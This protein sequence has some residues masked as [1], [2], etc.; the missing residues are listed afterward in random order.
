VNSLGHTRSVFALDHLL[1]TPDTFIRTVLPGMSRATAIVHASPALGAGFTA[2]TAEF[3][4]D[5]GLGPAQGQR[6]IYVLDGKLA[7]KR[8]EQQTELGSGGYAFVAQESDHFISSIEPSRLFVIEKPYT[9]CPGTGTPSTFTGNEAS[10]ENQALG[11]DPDLQVRPLLP[12]RPEFDF[13]VNT[14][15][16]APGASLS[17]VEI[18]VMEHA[19]L[20]LEGGGIYRLGDR[21]YPV[22]AGDFIWMRAY[23][24]QWFGAIGKTPAKY[25][26]YKDWNR[27]P[28]G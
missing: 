14:M 13:A 10:I 3:E 22:Q 1:Q 27:H 7:F 18:H 9:P 24:P 11:G 5:A 8:D 2:Y 16:Y 28:L 4:G 20:M 19:L 26:I 25:I 23:C 17:M 12:D 6:F 21:W 15:T